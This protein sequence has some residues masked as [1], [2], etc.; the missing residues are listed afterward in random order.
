MKRSRCDNEFYLSTKP[1]AVQE[2]RT[3]GLG[4]GAELGASITI[5]TGGKVY[6]PIEGSCVKEISK[7]GRQRFYPDPKAEGAH[8]VFRR[9]ATTG[10]ITH[11]E[12]YKPQTNP[13]NPTRWESV[14]RYDGNAASGAHF[15]KVTKQDIFS[16]HMHD[17]SCPG[18]I[19]SALLEEIPSGGL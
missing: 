12:T 2:F 3:L 8:T 13:R 5:E 15:N 16:P 19:R 9:D 14:M 7:G 10:K 4:K 11:Y 18:G 6:C 17:A 1:G